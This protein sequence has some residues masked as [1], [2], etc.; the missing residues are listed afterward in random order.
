MGGAEAR[1]GDTAGLP[2]AAAV[3]DTGWPRPMGWSERSAGCACLEAG[4]FATITDLAVAEKINASYVSRVLRLTLLPPDVVEAILDGR[5]PERM[6]LP[7][8]MKPFPVV[9]ER[10]TDMRGRDLTRSHRPGVNSISKFS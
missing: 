1:A 4:Q 10:Q 6:T 2:V 8:M 9:W 5:Q 7:G 3:A